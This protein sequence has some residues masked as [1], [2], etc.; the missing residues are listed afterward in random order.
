MQVLTPATLLKGDSNTGVFLWNLRFLRTSFIPVDAGRILKVHKAFRRCPGRLLNV[1]CTF[2]LQPA[3]AGMKTTASAPN[4]VR[5]NVAFVNWSTVFTEGKLPL[6]LNISTE[7][8]V[9][10]FTNSLICIDLTYRNLF[11]KYCEILIPVAIGKCPQ[12]L[13]KICSSQYLTCC[14]HQATQLSFT[15][16]KPTIETG[17]RGVK[18]VQS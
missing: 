1:L 5:Y 7:T 8:C 11:I 9:K 17:E 14:Y 10:K 13:Q 18:Y 15:C 6:Q 16:S 2:N 12:F 4:L 3:S